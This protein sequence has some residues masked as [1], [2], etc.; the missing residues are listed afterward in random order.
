MPRPACRGPQG[1]SR[2]PPYTGAGAGDVS[3][4]V[5]GELGA[6][7]APL[8]PEGGSWEAQLGRD[9][10]WGQGEQATDKQVPEAGAPGA[11][12]LGNRFLVL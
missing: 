5:L 8:A 2:L 3:G 12:V 7:C 11:L 4:R 6:A 10:I 1:G 9:G